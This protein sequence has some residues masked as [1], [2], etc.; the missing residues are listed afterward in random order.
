M[1]SETEEFSV[2]ED[3]SNDEEL[4][5]KST[6]GKKSV[7]DDSKEDIYCYEVNGEKNCAKE[8]DIPFDLK[9]NVSYSELT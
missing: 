3:N 1:P 2:C 9:S 4:Y 5:L 7:S 6:I 8:I